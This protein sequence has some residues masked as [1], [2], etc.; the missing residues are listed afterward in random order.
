MGQSR[1]R[2]PAMEFGTARIPTCTNRDDRYFTVTFQQMPTDGNTAMFANTLD[3]PNIKVDLNR[4]WD[5]AADRPLARRIVFTGPID[6]YFQ[7]CFGP[8]P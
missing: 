6:D 7:H 8:L 3:H 2:I 1:L 5:E 4:A